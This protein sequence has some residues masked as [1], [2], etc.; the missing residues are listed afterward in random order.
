MT[1]LKV[2]AAGCDDGNLTEAILG[3]ILNFCQPG[4]VSQ[5]RDSPIYMTSLETIIPNSFQAFTSASRGVDNVKLSRHL[6]TITQNSAVLKYSNGYR[7]PIRLRCDFLKAMFDAVDLIKLTNLFTSDIQR[8]VKISLVFLYTINRFAKCKTKLYLFCQ[9][10]PL[11]EYH[12]DNIGQ[13]TCTKNMNI[14]IFS[15][16]QKI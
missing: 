10:Y 11:F 15:N 1:T 13:L 7:T 12:D 6:K 5:G 3:Q 2:I 14:D 8:F 9:N 16:G 4:I